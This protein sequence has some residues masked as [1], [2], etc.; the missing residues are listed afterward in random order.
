[1]AA[2]PMVVNENPLVNLIGIYPNPSSGQFIIQSFGLKVQSFE[3][4][5]VLGEKVYQEIEN[6]YSFITHCILAN[7]IYFIHLETEKGIVVKKIVIA[8]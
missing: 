6:S 5:N 3:M 2:G 4:Y 1:M 7:G 8:H